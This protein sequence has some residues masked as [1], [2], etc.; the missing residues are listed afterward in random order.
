MADS[1]SA[2]KRPLIHR[3]IAKPGEKN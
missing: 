1:P 2:E 3:V